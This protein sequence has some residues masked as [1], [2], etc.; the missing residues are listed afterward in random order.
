MER[1]GLVHSVRCYR[2]G[3]T[4]SHHL[5]GAGD[6]A[7]VTIGVSLAIEDIMTIILQMPRT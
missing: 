4:H 2:Q 5:R 1:V 3:G 6:N 7:I